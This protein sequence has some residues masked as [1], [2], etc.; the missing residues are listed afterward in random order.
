MCDFNEKESRIMDQNHGTFQ[1]VR[2][3]KSIGSLHVAHG[4]LKPRRP[5][6]TLVELLVV[7]SIIAILIAL[8]LPALAKAKRLANSAVCASNLRQLGIA[9]AEYTQSSAESRDGFIYSYGSVSINSGSVWWISALAPMFGGS[10]AYVN[11]AGPYVVLPA[12]EQA[13]LICPSTQKVTYNLGSATVLSTWSWGTECSSYTLNGWMY[14]YQESLPAS[15]GALQSF[16]NGNNTSDFWYNSQS[17]PGA[18]APLFGDGIW[19]DAC[20]QPTDMP[21]VNLEGTVNPTVSMW[22]FCLNRHEGGI[23]MVFADSHVEHV[24]DADLWKLDWYPDFSP[25]KPWGGFAPPTN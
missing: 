17:I 8:L 1:I 6:F 4:S 11:P 20:P 18:T 3:A 13:T 9:Y 15:Q 5:A 12:T 22:R 21:P 23:N 14:N 19:I 25:K 10:N 2:P 7:I 24:M 16:G